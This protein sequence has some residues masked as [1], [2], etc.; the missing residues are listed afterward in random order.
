MVGK[1]FFFLEEK[2]LLKPKFTSLFEI[3]IFLH[4][5]VFDFEEKILSSVFYINV[6][7][8]FWIVL[9]SWKDNCTF[10]V[11]TKNIS[12]KYPP[13]EYLVS[14]LSEGAHLTWLP[15]ILLPYCGFLS[16]GKVLFW[17][18]QREHF[19]IKA[20][21]AQRAFLALLW[22]LLSAG[23]FCTS[24]LNLGVL[25]HTRFEEISLSWRKRVHDVMLALW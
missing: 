9:D 13:S 7:L 11:S 19:Y 16:W 18:M 17:K 5:S 20:I 22:A 2:Y 25:A 12:C 15:Q 4:D 8:E 10:T 6:L 23:W 1:Y 24:P 21:Q 3:H 14:F